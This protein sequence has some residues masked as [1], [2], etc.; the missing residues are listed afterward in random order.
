MVLDPVRIRLGEKGARSDPMRMQ[1][2]RIR[3]GYRVE[4]NMTG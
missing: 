2:D 1:Q 4:Y 3:S